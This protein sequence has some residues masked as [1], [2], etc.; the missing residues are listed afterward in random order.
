M[1]KTLEFLNSRRP[2]LEIRANFIHQLSAFETRLTANG[3]GP[4]TTKWTELYDHSNDFENEELLLRN[5]YLN[6]Q[7]GPMADLNSNNSKIQQSKIKFVEGKILATVM[8][9]VPHI[10]KVTA[11]NVTLSPIMKKGYAAPKPLQVP[12]TR[13]VLI[14]KERSFGAKEESRPATHTFDALPIDKKSYVRQPAEIISDTKKN[15]VESSKPKE[16]NI[17]AESKKVTEQADINIE[18][19]QKSNASTKPNASD[20]YSYLNAKPTYENY[21]MGQ[22]KDTPV[23]N[24]ITS[25]NINNYFIHDSSQV[26]VQVGP[27]SNIY[28]QGIEK[29]NVVGAQPK[30]ESNINAGFEGKQPRSYSLQ[31]KKDPNTQNT[32]SDKKPQDDNAHYLSKKE[33]P[34]KK[35]P[36]SKASTSIGKNVTSNNTKPVVHDHFK[37]MGDNKMFVQ[38]YFVQPSGNAMSSFRNGPIKATNIPANKSYKPDRPTSAAP[39]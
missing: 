38:N 15:T 10:T 8:P 30:F 2:D 28:L 19:R 3:M 36:S 1:L 13:N 16:Y 37:Y 33:D 9:E 25:N 24:I 12:Q 27:N 11:I 34:L 5:T 21:S 22:Y 23:T 7:I 39:K 31:S 26:Q 20:A 18:S 14:S 32:Y 29:I 17:K 4:K 35:P 6:A